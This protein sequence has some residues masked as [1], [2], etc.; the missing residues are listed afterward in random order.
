MNPMSD[1]AT[2]IRGMDDFSGREWFIDFVD[3]WLSG[4]GPQTPVYCLAAEPGWGKTRLAKHLARRHPRSLSIEGRRIPSQDPG[5]VLWSDLWT[6]M[7]LLTGETPEWPS[8]YAQILRRLREVKPTLLIADRAESLA[9]LTD[10]PVLANLLESGCRILLFGRPGTYLDRLPEDSVTLDLQNSQSKLNLADLKTWIQKVKAPGELALHAQGNFGIARE[11]FKTRPDRVLQ[12]QWALV[13]DLLESVGP[14]LRDDAQRVLCLLAESKT[15]LTARAVGSFLALNA[16]R[17]RA[18]LNALEPLLQF[19]NE[20]FGLYSPWLAAAISNVLE[21]DLEVIHANVIGYFRETFPSWDEMTDPY[22]WKY[23]LHHGDRYSRTSKRRDFSVLHWLGEGPFLRLKLQK[24][25][26]LSGVLEDLRLAL[27]AAMEENDLPRVVSY[28]FQIPRLRRETA[29]NG[30][31]ELADLGELKLAR[32]YALLLTNDANRF[33]GLVLLAWQICSGPQEGPAGTGFESGRG[34]DDSQRVLLELLLLDLSF[35]PIVDLAEESIP[36]LVH[37]VAD[38]LR[39]MPH[40]QDEVLSLLTRNESA[41]RRAVHFFMLSLIE[42]QTPEL[43]EL[44]LRRGIQAAEQLPDEERDQL[45]TM[46]AR[47]FERQH[48]ESLAALLCTGKAGESKPFASRDEFLEQRSGLVA[49]NA[50][51]KGV[52]RL[53]QLAE[54]LVAGEA[55]PP[56]AVEELAVLC[57]AVVNLP[58]EQEKLRAI[59]GLSRRLGPLESNPDSLRAFEAL[60]AQAA[61][62]EDRSLKARAMAELGVALHRHH[63]YV[64]SNDVISQSAGIAFGVE[65]KAGR[66][67]TLLFVAGAV[68]QTL[69]P[70]RAQDLAF[71]ALQCLEGKLEHALDQ[72]CRAVLKLGVL[73]TISSERVIENLEQGAEEVRRSAA[74]E[75]RVKA[76][77]LSSLAEGAHKLGATE[78]AR[79]LLDQALASARV[80]PPGTAKCITLA[81]LALREYEARENQ[82]K[83][84][85]L[86]EA[87]EAL[88]VETSVTERAE[89]LL[90]IA[91]SRLDARDPKAQSL[92]RTIL[93]ELEKSPI[94][95]VLGCPSL[96]KFVGL[97]RRCN[98]AAWSHKL[99][100]KVRAELGQLKEVTEGRDFLLLNLIAFELAFGEVEAAMSRLQL[101]QSVRAHA[102]GQSA[103]AVAMIRERPEQA[104]A[105]IAS[106]TIQSTRLLAIERSAFEL[107]REL[108]PSR[109]L[110]VQR[111]MHSL[112]LLATEDEATTDMVLSRWLNERPDIH[113]LEQ[114]ARKMGWISEDPPHTPKAVHFKSL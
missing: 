42:G 104:L 56:W 31:H 39:L 13:E 63:E 87:M 51:G 79:Q 84:Q 36:L 47:S 27:T 82:R 24:T 99:L 64:R 17:T 4:T 94:Q 103:V 12:R 48:Q 28:G 88:A 57:Q 44:E 26:S 61:Y 67:H 102:D 96:S 111:T 2:E 30:L 100:T 10:G 73:S 98:L 23:L 7:D 25:R 105:M 65:S 86:Q 16:G 9:V 109:K 78:W 1:I 69:H 89:G 52:D 43:R 81:Q 29:A 114:T 6:S 80:M 37:I 107:A 58:V 38:L 11:L 53:L 112:T 113:K 93:N 68:A 70:L 59:Q 50:Q 20:R 41:L 91:A 21:K 106:I 8:S 97:T 34:D 5:Q 66:A 76:L 90:A 101:L 83:E 75:P 74:G 49:A 33:L 22:G 85:V 108:R 46:I 77:A 54:R 14:T 3:S 40:R 110:Q 60:L 62:L 72:N 92:L 32:E 35:I 71:N 45:E 55:L 15:P 19:Q 95:H 18:L